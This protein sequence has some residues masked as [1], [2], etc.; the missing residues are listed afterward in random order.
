MGKRIKLVIRKDGKIAMDFDGFVGT[1]C[2]DEAK[3]IKRRLKELGVEMDL[4]S[5][6]PKVP[7]IP[8][9]GPERQKGRE[10]S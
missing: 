5:A 9:A 7:R 8:E 1:N 4:E 3:E 10:K 2:V 6:T